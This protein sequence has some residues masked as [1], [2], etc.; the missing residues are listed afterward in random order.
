MRICAYL[1][2]R[3]TIL[4]SRDLTTSLHKRFLG[5]VFVTADFPR[6]FPVRSRR[7]LPYSTRLRSTCLSAV[8]ACHLVLMHSLQRF[9]HSQKQL[10]QPLLR[11]LGVI[12]QIRIDHVLQVPSSVV[13]QKY[14]DRLCAWIRLVACDGVIDGVDDIWIRREEAVC[15]DLLERERD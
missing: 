11:E 9:A 1:P 15:F 5:F 4:T 13:R 6:S 10:H 2:W 14:V 7:F 3:N 8:R 12:D